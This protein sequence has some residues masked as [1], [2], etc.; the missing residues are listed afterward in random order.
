MCLS[1]LPRKRKQKPANWRE[2][3][4]VD[5]SVLAGAL[6]QRV[7]DICR[8]DLDLYLG[9]EGDVRIVSCRGIFVARE[10]SDGL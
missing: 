2:S 3:F 1:R 10:A 4:D 8:L 9:E 6:L 5:G 7:D